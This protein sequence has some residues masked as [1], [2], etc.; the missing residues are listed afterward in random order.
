MIKMGY[1]KNYTLI[2]CTS[3]TLILGQSF[4]NQTNKLTTYAEEVT[5]GYVEETYTP[6]METT[7][8]KATT[9]EKTTE[10]ENT[11][12]E[13]T[14][15]YFPPTRI[16]FI[17]NSS[18]YYNNMPDM[19]ASLANAN[20]K[21]T[22]ILK[23][24][25]AN[26]KLSDFTNENDIYYSLITKTL[27]TQHWDYI[28]IQEHRNVIIQN[29]LK[30]EQELS[31]F[32][33][34]ITAS[35]A[36]LILYETQADFSGKNFTLNNSTSFLDHV[37][38]QYYMT[39]SY[40]SIANK[41]NATVSPVGVNYTRCMEM[42]PEI[43]LYNEDNL[44]P[45]IEGSYL[46]ACTLYGTIFGESA[47]NTDYFIKNPKE[48]TDITE[49]EAM[50]LQSIADARLSLDKYNI[51]MQKTKSTSIKGTFHIS[52]DNPVLSSFNNKVE[53]FSLDDDIIAVNRYTGTITALAVGD[54]MIMATT[55]SGLMAMCSI[56]VK[57]PST[58]LT[59][60]ETGI[61]ELLKNETTSF[62]ATAKPNDTT[63]TI[64]WTSSDSSIASVDSN[65]VVTAK[66]AGVVIVTA[67]TDSGLTVTRKVRVNLATP[68]KV[69]VKK[70][71]TKAKNTKYANLRITWKKNKNAVKYA[72][73]RSTKEK[74]GY[75]RIATVTTAK[76]TDK[77]KR[78]GKTYYYKIKAI[79]SNIKCNS[80][81]SA[82][83]KFKVK[84]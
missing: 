51:V 69:K 6:P 61:K 1:L 75:K 36:Q 41:F 28:V 38:T 79:F 62:S 59:I 50:K 35:K 80:A 76:Y 43:V 55:D 11:E 21:N 67:K 12:E 70:L 77:N 53:Y 10:E 66:K 25:H 32:Y 72:V 84:K 45:S 46:A 83:V 82:P 15:S 26:F 65:G 57:Q 14:T 60:K 2:L 64:T 24:T 47:Y 71:K 31:K 58:S 56:T 27:T 3:L 73:Y 49:D 18:T 42:Y 13:T 4:I 34:A 54:G 40:Y 16:L 7:T 23:I 48:K 9:E 81:K 30:T 20:N 52:G 17:G 68:T 22:E 8:E 74:S 37:Q 33:N 39:K 19:V 29:P 5:I 78:K 44:H 63:D